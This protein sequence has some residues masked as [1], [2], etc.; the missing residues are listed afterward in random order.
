[1]RI[2]LF[3]LFLASL[4]YVYGQSTPKVYRTYTARDDFFI[5]EHLT[6]GTDGIFFYSLSCEC[7]NERYAK[8]TW[9][10]I[11]DKLYLNGFD[12]ALAFP[13]SKVEIIEGKKGEQVI[14]SA[15]NHY[16][17]P[18]SSLGVALLNRDNINNTGY[19]YADSTGKITVDKK[20]YQGFT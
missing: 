1:M 15:T 18:I 17:L 20:E 13:Q 12:S 5:G 10:I 8:G 3:I 7:G 16:G 9:K 4:T 14:I 2:S 6:L 19:A 11:G